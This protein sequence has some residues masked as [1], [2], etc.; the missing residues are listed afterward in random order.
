M[1]GIARW[2][3]WSERDI[4]LTLGA[5]F[6]A[7]YAEYLGLDPHQTFI[8]FL[9][10]L[11]IR[12]FRLVSYWSDI[13]PQ[14]GVYNFS[15]LDWEF[16][17][18]EAR[19]AKVSLAI[20]LRQ[21]RWPECHL[22]SWAQSESDNTIQSQL[23]QYLAVIIGRY[24]HSPALESYQLENEYFLVGF[25]TCGS[26]TRDRLIAE[27]NLVRALDPSHTLIINRSDNADGW[28]IHKPTADEYGISIYRRV[29]TPVLGR[30][31]EYPFPAWYYAF[32]AGAEKIWSGKDTIIHELQMEP[33]PPHREQ[34]LTSTL[35]EQNK[36]FNADRMQTTL[37]FGK[38]TGMRTIDLWGA[39]YWYY[40]KVKLHDS[41]VWDTAKQDYQE[42]RD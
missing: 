2:Y 13:E 21:P 15:E 19:N 4:P 24:K 18:A 38:S 14:K 30:Y 41:S 20:G 8:A 37:T 39:E 27:A 12:Q 23:Q 16:Q 17:Q 7:D 10:D 36:S 28:P 29:W 25:G 42:N 22:P 32:M 5:S 1:Y 11:H 26:H 40:R 9:D 35:A 6:V 31:I 33:W 34:I 3:I